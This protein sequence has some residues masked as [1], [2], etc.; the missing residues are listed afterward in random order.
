MK[1]HPDGTVEGTPQ[2]IAEYMKI[3]SELE[4]LSFAEKVK[5]YREEHEANVLAI[6]DEMAKNKAKSGKVYMFIDGLI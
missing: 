2:E 5:Q 6:L 1:L 4:D 3:G